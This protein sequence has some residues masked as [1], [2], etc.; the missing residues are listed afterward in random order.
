MSFASDFQKGIQIGTGFSEA[1][2]PKP[3]IRAH[4]SKML[5]GVELSTKEC[6]SRMQEIMTEQGIRIKINQ[7]VMRQSRY[8]FN[9]RWYLR[10][11]RGRYTYY[12]CA[13]PE[14]NVFFFSYWLKESSGLLARLVKVLPFVGKEWYSS[15]N[16]MSFYQADVYSVFMKVVEDAIMQ[17]IEEMTQPLTLNRKEAEENQAVLQRFPNQTETGKH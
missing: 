15:L 17:T 13:A 8:S 1:I 14:G 7:V 11:R 12:I 16:S 4:W 2:R 10:V 9:Q 3:N 5:Y 6:Y